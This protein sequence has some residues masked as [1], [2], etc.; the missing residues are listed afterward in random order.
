LRAVVGS[1]G[2][3]HRRLR[4]GLQNSPGLI[5]EFGANAT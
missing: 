2:V 5:D 3:H 1:R 4:D